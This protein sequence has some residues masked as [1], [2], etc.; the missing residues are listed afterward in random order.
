MSL[1]ELLIQISDGVV[2]L[3]IIQEINLDIDSLELLIDTL[4]NLYTDERLDLIH[5]KLI[6]DKFIE[7]DP[8]IGSNFFEIETIIN[9]ED[10]DILE[11]LYKKFRIN[12]TDNTYFTKFLD[13][14]IHNI[15]DYNII[16][17]YL[18]CDTGKLSNT[19]YNT[20]YDKTII[21][22]IHKYNKF[23]YSTIDIVSTSVLENTLKL[24]KDFQIT[25]SQL[26][27]KF[28]FKYI[29]RAIDI[30]SNAKYYIKKDIKYY[31]LY[32]QIDII[33]NLDSF[34]YKIY[35]HNTL[36]ICDNYSEVTE[37]NLLNDI[38]Q[39][40]K[41]FNFLVNYSFIEYLT[42]QDYIH[43]NFG[44]LTGSLK[45]SLPTYS[46]FKDLDNMIYDTPILTDIAGKYSCYIP[47]SKDMLYIPNT[48]IYVG[49]NL[50]G[51]N[52]IPFTHDKII[53]LEFTS[54]DRF[55]ISGKNV[56]FPSNTY[57][58]VSGE[59]Y[60]CNYTLIIPFKIHS[61]T[62]SVYD[63][64]SYNYL[65]SPVDYYDVKILDYIKSGTRLP[66]NIYVSNS[67]MIEI[68]K[69][70]DKNI[71]DAKILT[72][73]NKNCLDIGIETLTYPIL[74]NANFCYSYIKTL[75]RLNTRLN[76]T[77]FEFL[78]LLYLYIKDTKNYAKF[79]SIFIKLA[80]IKYHNTSY[81]IYNY[82][83]EIITFHYVIA[84]LINTGSQYITILGNNGI[85]SPF[86]LMDDDYI[87]NKLLVSGLITKLPSNISLNDKT[88]PYIFALGYKIN[89]V[90][91]VYNKEN[92]KNYLRL[93]ELYDMEYSQSSIKLVHFDKYIYFLPTFNTISDVF[94]GATERATSVEAQPIFR[95][96]KTFKITLEYRAIKETSRQHINNYYKCFYQKI[97]YNV[98]KD[99]IE[100]L[101]KL[102][103]VED[104]NMSNIEKLELDETA[105][106][107]NTILCSAFLLINYYT[108]NYGFKIMHKII[109]GEDIS[110]LLKR[111]S[112]ITLYKNNEFY[113]ETMLER[114]KM[115][116]C[117]N[118]FIYDTHKQFIKLERVPP[119][120]LERKII[121]FRGENKLDIPISVGS[122]I[123]TLKNQFISF[124]SNFNTVLT[125]TKRIV[126]M[127][128]IDVERDVVLPI[129]SIK[130]IYN[131]IKLPL[132]EISGEDEFL[133]PLGT[134]LIVS[135]KPFLYKT[136]ESTFLTILPVKIHSQNKPNYKK[137][138][139]IKPLYDNLSNITKNLI[140][141]I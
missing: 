82:N 69:Y 15:G 53:L 126:H 71:Q 131:D 25:G 28:L 108:S 76:K 137:L 48:I 74:T 11:Y 112:S 58:I 92:G 72:K 115:I 7:R 26:I 59:P 68:L 107:T 63:T 8:T 13:K 132:T 85:F 134:N 31:R 96:L 77:P 23:D 22:L 14:N 98:F 123:N 21:K 129:G 30:M 1:D 139:G 17:F 117:L 18:K 67:I 97:Y 140:N 91:M 10:L 113:V 124:S 116:K 94:V 133:L 95:L 111:Q 46:T 110:S 40:D 49:E 57:Y 90:H 33:A 32:N 61:Q 73:F 70:I 103:G 5:F 121:L 35:D 118:N 109:R 16:E 81:I 29:F 4:Y 122:I 99:D 6:L 86:D 47:L 114:I 88:L 130:F 78:R 83:H 104:I 20:L 37:D 79:V 24:V 62:K 56:I 138:T 102:A 125:F 87:F 41:L 128:E 66:S 2:D 39:S 120:L 50:T 51:S 52:T 55:I 93:N 141:I 44:T 36:V 60:I 89:S 80:N 135:D 119:C 34:V 54:N 12:N 45:S 105:E 43:I 3:D 75:T 64:V 136:T 27:S 65:I 101:F 100:K 106:I 84:E 127:L 19:M 38:E 42:R 9:I